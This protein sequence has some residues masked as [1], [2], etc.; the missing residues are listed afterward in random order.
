LV[1]NLRAGAWIRYGFIVN[2]FVGEVKK[3][4]PRPKEEFEVEEAG[5]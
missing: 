1:W 2:L 3:R 5:A 4:G